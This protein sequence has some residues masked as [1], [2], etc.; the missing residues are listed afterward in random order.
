[1]E[2]RKSGIRLEVMP[3]QNLCVERNMQRLETVHTGYTGDKTNKSRKLRRR[4]LGMVRL[5]DLK[6][7]GLGLINLRKAGLRVGAH[8]DGLQETKTKRNA[9]ERVSWLEA[10]SWILSCV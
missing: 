3:N 7:S 2:L 4:D 8:M 5:R 6:K 9:A 1:M 10:L